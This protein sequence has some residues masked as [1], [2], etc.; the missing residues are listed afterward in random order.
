ML[1]TKHD[2]TLRRF[3]TVAPTGSGVTIN[4]LHPAYRGARSIFPSRVFA[5]DEIGR[6]LK[7]GHNSRKI[8]KEVRKGRGAGGL[9][10]PLPW[11]SGPLAR[12]PVTCGASATEIRCRPR[13][14][15][16]PDPG[17]KKRWLMNLRICNAIIPP[18]SWS[19]CTSLVTSTAPAM[20]S[21]GDEP[22][23]TS[24]PCTYSVSRRGCPGPRSATRCGSWLRP[25]GTDSQFV[26]Q[27]L[28]CQPNPRKSGKARP[29]PMPSSA[30]P[31]P[32]QRTAARPACS[33]STPTAR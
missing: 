2:S 22:S 28:V 7:S 5:P 19:G 25:D 30:R 23:T 13:S 18:A 17:W 10:T 14:A 20:S 4:S 33:A 31:R 16:P 24:R 26:F 11:R 12:G 15:S 1:K 3:A 8:G 32:D 21:S 27:A 9:F 29:I 6:L